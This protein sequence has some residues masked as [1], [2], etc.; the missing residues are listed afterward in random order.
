MK[1]HTTYLT[2]DVEELEEDVVILDAML[3]GVRTSSLC[4]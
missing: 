4:K 1:L 2:Y 3:F